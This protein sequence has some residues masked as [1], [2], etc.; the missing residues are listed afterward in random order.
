MENLIASLKKIGEKRPLSPDERD[1]DLT[2][3]IGNEE[4]KSLKLKIHTQSSHPMRAICSKEWLRGEEGNKVAH[5]EVEAKVGELLILL[6]CPAFDANSIP[7]SDLT[8]TEIVSIARV[9]NLFSLENE[10]VR[11]KNRRATG[12]S[13]E[14][15]PNCC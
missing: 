15:M 11:W 13:G 5:F 1:T 10:G 14:K 12:E 7:N 3:Q 6:I 8:P 2:M 4:G 9:I